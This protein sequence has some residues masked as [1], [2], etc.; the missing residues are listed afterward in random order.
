MDALLGQMA[1]VAVLFLLPLW[2][3]YD[4]AGLSPVL[5]LTVLIPGVGPLI[6]LWILAFLPWKLSSSEKIEN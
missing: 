5:S 1:A 4:Q 6:S 2:R 3:I